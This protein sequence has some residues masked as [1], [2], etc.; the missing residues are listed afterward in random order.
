MF[1]LAILGGMALILLF[2]LS[3]LLY[4][5]RYMFFF[6]TCFLYTSQL[7]PYIHCWMCNNHEYFTI[8][9]A[10]LILLKQHLIYS[11]MND[12]HMNL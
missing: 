6:C 4:Y 3:L 9:N 12:Q 11:I 2:L 7:Q 1:L 8:N 10:N 5:C